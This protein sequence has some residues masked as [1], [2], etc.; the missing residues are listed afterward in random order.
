MIDGGRRRDLTPMA[1]TLGV[2]LCTL[3]F[4]VLLV[5]PWFGVRVALGVAL[6]VLAAI[7]VVCWLAQLPQL[8][9]VTVVFSDS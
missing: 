3:P 1:L 7:S 8:T 6:G 9:G 2:A 5:V 4:V